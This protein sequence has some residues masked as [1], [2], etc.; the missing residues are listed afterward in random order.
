M[1]ATGLVFHQETLLAER[2]ISK[3]LAMWLISFQAATAT[4]AAFVAGPLTDRLPT[5]KL[6]AGAMLLLGC[7]S[8][9]LLLMPY[10]SFVFGFAILNGLHGSILR[11]AG[12]VVWVNYYGRKN[13]GV[14]RGVAFS[15][16]ILAAAIGPLPL[17]VSKDR[18]GS[19]SLALLAF[20]IIPLLSM[21]LVL[22]AKRPT[23]ALKTL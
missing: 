1:I 2:G 11:T 19:Y 6:M 17:A 9:V 8:G 5:E 16:M 7:A 21:L 14:I 15:M 12:T 10:W 3:D 23:R 4:L 13:Q 22:T 18:L 20:A